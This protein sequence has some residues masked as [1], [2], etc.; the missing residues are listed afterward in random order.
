M[1]STLRAQ[2]AESEAEIS[3]EPSLEKGI[4][5]VQ[6]PDF[7]PLTPP[8]PTRPRDQGPSRSPSL[9]PDDPTRRESD[10]VWRDPLADNDEE[11]GEEERETKRQ[12][13]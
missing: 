8:T 1:T 13:V 9:E 7:R 4:E 5:P 6:S 11:E 10:T 2:E 3:A 12:R